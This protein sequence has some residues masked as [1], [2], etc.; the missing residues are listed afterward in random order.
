MRSRQAAEIGKRGEDIAVKY[1]EGC[2]FGILDRNWNLHKGC[3]IDIIAHRHGVIHF[4]EV[5]TRS[6]GCLVDPEWAINR[7]KM[8]HIYKAAKTYV[9]QHQMQGIKSQIDSIAIILRKDDNYDLTFHED[10]NFMDYRIY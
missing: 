4:V 9:V 8:K 10:I 6:Q 5:K 1:L 3:E 7:D 2:G